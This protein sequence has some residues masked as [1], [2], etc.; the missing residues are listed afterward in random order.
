MVHLACSK[1]ANI[2]TPTEEG[3][4][5]A[6]LFNRR[7]AESATFACTTSHLLDASVLKMLQRPQP[8]ACNGFWGVIF[9]AP[10]RILGP[11]AGLILLHLVRMIRPKLPLT[12]YFSFR[13]LVRHC[14]YYTPTVV[15]IVP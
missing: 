1:K 11:I 12:L 2:T 13:V 6:D 14:W 7:G 4:S 5:T 15:E 8:T 3:P 10:V 9:G